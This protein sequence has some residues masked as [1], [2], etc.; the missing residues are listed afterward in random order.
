VTR[1]DFKAYA[2]PLKTTYRYSKG[3]FHQRCGL[4]VRAE[5]DGH[6]GWGEAAPAPCVPVDGPAY[7]HQA[8][9]LING[10]DIADDQF[11][12]K[13]D[14]R[15]PKSSLRCGISTAWLSASASAKGMSL[16]R[17]IYTGKQEPAETIPVNGLVVDDT[18]E[19]A[20]EQAR[21]YID[22]GMKTIKI[23]CFT[24]FER[25]LARVGA[26]RRAFPDAALRLDPNEAW[27][28]A[29]ALNYLEKMS[30]FNIEYI[31]DALPPD[32]SMETF[33][34]LR[35]KS[36]IK[37]AW[38]EPAQSIKAIRNLID[39]DAVDVLI[40]KLYRT[41]GPDRLFDMIRLSEQHDIQ[42]TVTSSLDTAIGTTAAL[43][44]ASLL[45]APIPDCGMGISHFLERDVASV[46]P[47]ENGRMR[48]P[49]G[50]GLGLEDVIF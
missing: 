21:H 27:T 11:L 24:D 6:I 29:V 48:V 47:I 13:L 16:N 14:D 2:L 43:H 41:G 37:L 9:T 4:L 22:T 42:C 17:F 10:L 36:P 50:P 35:S 38:D 20:L 33:A 46:P 1:I 34:E 28:E 19:G 12:R 26:I 7:A 8:E 18:I 31:E 40:L 49:S 45:P 3:V 23:K 30:R 25:D 32:R 39:A 15:K 44:C 5:I